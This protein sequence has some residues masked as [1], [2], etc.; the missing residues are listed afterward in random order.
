MFLKNL[1]FGTKLKILF[2][3]I[4]LA[5]LFTNGYANFILAKNN[6]QNY[7]LDSL[8]LLADLTK[9]DLLSFEAQLK[10]RAIDFSSDGFIRDS[11][12]LLAKSSD[13]EVALA[14]CDHLAKNKM[15]LDSTIYGINVTDLSGRILAST[16]KTEVGQ[17]EAAHEYFLR[18]QNL[19]Y[20]EASVGDVA[21][22]HHFGKTSPEI[23]V[24][25]PLFEKSNGKKIGFIINYIDAKYLS[26]VAKA[27]ERRQVAGESLYISLEQTD[28][29]ETVLINKNKL[30]LAESKFKSDELVL[31]EKIETL[32]VLE[33]AQNRTVNGPFTDYRGEKVIGVSRCLDHG[34]T[35]VVK[36]D[37][38][39]A[40]GDLAQTRNYTILAGFLIA[41]LL[42]FAINFF[43]KKITRPIRELLSV[44]QKIGKGNLN[45]RVKIISKD[46][47]GEFAEVFNQMTSDL[48]NLYATLEKRIKEK[49][50]TLEEQVVEL[51]KFQLAVANT[52]DH[53]VIT[54][55]DGYTLYANAAVE[56]ITGYSRKE[57]I[58]K[59][60]S[61]WG[62]LM[63]EK[64]YEKM[65]K[66][67]KDDKKT[68][69]GELT[70]QRKNGEKYIAE[71]R[72][73]PIL[74]K[75][76]RVVFFVGIE[77]DITKA[78]E[79]DRAKTELISLASHQLRTPL[80]AVKWYAEMLTAQKTGKL[81]AKQKKYLDEI[82]RGNERM[83]TLV[84]S[85]LNVSRI[86][87]G[88]F[89][90]TPKPEDIGKIADSSLPDFE[91]QIKNKKITLKKEY[92]PALP[93]INVDAKLLRIV[94]QNLLSNAVKYTPEKGKI[95]LSITRQKSAVLIRI[96]D[97]GIGI[98]KEAQVKIFTKL[99]RADN[100]K[101]TD[102]S[103]T[104]LGL[105]I[106]KAIVDASG[107][108]IWFESEENK[109]TTFYVTL[110]LKGVRRKAG[111]VGLELTP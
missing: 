86:D 59:K 14:L 68:F 24:A 36:V 111:T 56:K 45:Q 58:G 28:T 9:N 70:N 79:I 1:K 2:L 91:P 96:A 15:S 106:V 18:G 81:T 31:K 101:I 55:P 41:I 61:L 67:I 43:I 6:I 103:G 105:Y 100:A 48:Q 5:S 35:L 11:A 22:S 37:Q 49:T 87:L 8:N 65:W 32:P 7:L 77:R 38:R 74:D 30:L 47:I 83:I 76:G 109:G 94:F 57:I 95:I 107:G 12:S 102:P 84:G 92:N 51:K 16:D 4:V 90:I 54:D 19:P 60:T 46:E 73:S 53:V 13:S 17:N 20:G 71:V 97:D 25:A 33:C 93:K 44:A 104:G 99:F 21:L 80:T 72:I 40:F 78:K 29:F 27:R 69:I 39:E 52:A 26:D 64:F 3:T 62:N 75:R 42:S 89:A 66:T 23:A 63:D 98:P 50:K 10:N 85:L 110:P 108:K 34:W 88:T 82:Y